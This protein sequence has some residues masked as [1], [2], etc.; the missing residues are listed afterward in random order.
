MDSAGLDAL[1]R[2]LAL[3]PETEV[4]EPRAADHDA[5]SVP[6]TRSASPSLS[7]PFSDITSGSVPGT[8]V[9]SGL[10]VEPRKK[11]KIPG[12]TAVKSRLKRKAPRRRMKKKTVVVP[13]EKKTTKNEP[14]GLDQR[15]FIV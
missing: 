13:V 3:A 15:E 14:G 10:I 4:L 8:P 11:R 1:V 7:I 6:S 5:P 2:D 12:F 9:G